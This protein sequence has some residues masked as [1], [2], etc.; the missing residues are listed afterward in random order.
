MAAEGWQNH[1]CHHYPANN[2]GVSG[3]FSLYLLI[4]PV[5]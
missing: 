1:P 4:G 2:A 5:L 3:Y